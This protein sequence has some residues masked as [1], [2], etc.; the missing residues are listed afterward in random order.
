M[1][2]TDLIFKKQIA[3]Y[4]LVQYDAAGNI[5]HID[6]FVPQIISWMAEKYDFT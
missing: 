5:S 1:P 4:V 6:G 2:E 3:P